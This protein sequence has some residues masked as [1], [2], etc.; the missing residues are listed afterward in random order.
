MEEGALIAT[1]RTALVDSQPVDA[2]QLAEDGLVV[3]GQPS[4]HDGLVGG[5]PVQPGAVPGSPGRRVGLIL[6]VVADTIGLGAAI[7]AG[8]IFDLEVNGRGSISASF[9]SLMYLPLLLAVMACYGLY[10]RGGRRIMGSSFPDVGHLIHALIVGS[11][12]T[13][14]A[15][16]GMHRWAGLPNIDRTGIGVT[17]AIA[18]ITVTQARAGARWVLRRGQY[19]IS[20]IL[21]VG[22]G[23]VATAVLARLQKVEGVR[24]VGCVDDSHRAPALPWPSTT[25]LGGLADIPEIVINERVDH[26]VVAFSPAKGA[27]L[28]GLLRPQLRDVRVS[29]VPRLFELMTVRSTV[30]ELYGLP[31]VDVA[32]ASFGLADRFAKRTMDMVVSGLGLLAVSIPMLVIAL[33]VRL[34]SPGPIFFRQERTGRN[35]LPFHIYKFRT[36]RQGA[37]QEK[38]ALAND[39]DG[40]LFK[41]HND[42]RVTKVG[43]FLRKTSLDELPQLINVFKGDMSLVGPRPFITSESEAI[44]GWATRRFDVRPGMTGL[45]QV[46]GRND[47][48]FEELC[49]LDHS[50]VASWSLWWDLRILWYTPGMVFRR[51]GAY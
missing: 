5:L 17:V 36:M 41:N 20:K 6:A 39:V 3:V 46:S 12:I 24:V 28:A 23:E 29:V 19:G 13:L 34:T 15:A 43:A 45:W 42:P 35:N 31:V 7:V 32:P 2:V 48:P 26:V 49:R 4:G 27:E 22:S 51:H 40:P 10:R 9:A 25:L 11:L 47:L 16:A 50:Y 37:E 44:C 30:D 21:I 18:V 1:T 8:Q 14:L 33:A 38:Q